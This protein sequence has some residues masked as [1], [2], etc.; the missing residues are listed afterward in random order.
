MRVFELILSVI[1]TL[2]N[3]ATLALTI[4]MIWG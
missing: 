4:Y 3:I 1:T 2:C